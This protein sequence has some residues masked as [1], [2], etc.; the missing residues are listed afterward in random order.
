MPY[1]LSTI[2]TL[3]G[4]L[5][6][7]RLGSRPLT[8]EVKSP[9][10]DRLKRRTPPKPPQAPK[11]ASIEDVRAGKTALVTDTSNDSDSRLTSVG[12]LYQ[13]P[14][15][16]LSSGAVAQ[17][18]EDFDTVSDPLSGFSVPNLADQKTKEAFN[19]FFAPG[20]VGSDY[21]GVTDA[22][23]L[24]DQDPTRI[25]FQNQFF[26]SETLKDVNDL[27]PTKLLFRQKE[28]EKRNK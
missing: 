23:Q 25:A 3:G 16:G 14:I 6:G 11:Q 22:Q 15:A 20:S 18:Q 26:A 1:D 9:V 10:R 12:N 13:A 17:K 28:L 5:T 7:T 4:D 27:T 2:Q 21:R 8:K 24:R 19:R